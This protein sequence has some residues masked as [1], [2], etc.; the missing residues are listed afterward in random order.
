MVIK[1][2]KGDKMFNIEAEY[3]NARRDRLA[4]TYGGDS[5]VVIQGTKILCVAR[6][7]EAANN[8]VAQN[9]LNNQVYINR[10]L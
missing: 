4:E 5:Y 1:T 2:T 8:Y 7:E 10:I 3:V 6:S 9:G